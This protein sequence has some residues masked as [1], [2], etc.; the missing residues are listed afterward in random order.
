MLVDKA[1][2][3]TWA[4]RKA[5]FTV[6][7]KRL[8]KAGELIETTLKQTVG[9]SLRDIYVT[10]LVKCPA[11]KGA[12]VS[13]R[14]LKACRVHLQR[15]IE[16]VKPKIIVA[17]GHDAATELIPGFR[18]LA[19]DRGVPFERLDGIMILATYHPLYALR[20]YRTSEFREDFE[21]AARML[22]LRTSQQK[23]NL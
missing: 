17:L 23:A 21:E 5:R 20:H 12:A 14:E 9:L 1:P 13:S 7:K 2:L 6:T 3:L 11:E 15:E 16:A 10:D 8:S 18:N 19:W 4:R 22:K